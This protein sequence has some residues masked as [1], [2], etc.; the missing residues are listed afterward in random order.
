MV[1]APVDKTT[2]FD[3]LPTRAK[4]D[5]DGSGI[6]SGS[7]Q[8]NG[9][10]IDNN[11]VTIGTTAVALNGSS[12][13]L[14][15]L[16]GLDFTA[17]DASIAASIGANTLTL[18]GSTSDIVVAGNLTVQGTTTTV[19]ST[20]VTIGDNI[21]ELNY[22]GSATEGG[23]YVKDGTGSN[24]ASGSLV[25]DSTNDYWKAGALGSEAEISRFGADPTANTIQKANANGLLVDSVLTDDGTDATFSGDVTVS[26]L[27]ASRVVVTDSSSKLATSTDISALTLTL[28]GGTF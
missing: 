8:V 23:I 26:G 3:F 9:A 18:G 5:L 6:V 17:A 28:D 11:T 20:N 13:T 1:D 21:L 10:N 24:T 12:T 22:G 15:G 2:G 7:G 19:D 14:A 16:T 27:T 4:L 25:W